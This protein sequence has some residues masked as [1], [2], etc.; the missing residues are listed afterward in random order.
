M[1]SFEKVWKSTLPLDLNLTILRLACLQDG[2]ESV[3][4]HSYNHS[5]SPKK[6]SP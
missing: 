3:E 1:Q 5:N 6:I 4:Y 2:V